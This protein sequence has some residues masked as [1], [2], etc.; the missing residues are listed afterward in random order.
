MLL[1]K[2]KHRLIPN[3]G[4]LYKGRKTVFKDG[5]LLSGY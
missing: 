4:Q 5:R 3:Y 1:K 2:K